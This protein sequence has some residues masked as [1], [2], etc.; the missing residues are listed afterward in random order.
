MK[1]T[2]L[3]LLILAFMGCATMQ[4]APVNQPAPAFTVMDL[5]GQFINLSDFKGK[6]IVL[7]FYV[8]HD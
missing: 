5:S 8:N 2:V 7:V 1:R 6:N 4:R 3:F